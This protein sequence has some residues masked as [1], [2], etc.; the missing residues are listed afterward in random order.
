MAYSTK[1]E[2]KLLK[3][4]YALRH[5]HIN[6]RD[7]LKYFK[8]TSTSGCQEKANFYNDFIILAEYM[9]NNLKTNSLYLS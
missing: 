3:F 2:D 4:E 9:K 5:L 6:M 1:A 8:L 7:I